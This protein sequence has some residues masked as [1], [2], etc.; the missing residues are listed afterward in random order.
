MELL[1][2]STGTDRVINWFYWDRRSYRLVLLGQTELLTGSTWRRGGGRNP[3][4]ANSALIPPKCCGINCIRCSP[5]QCWFPLDRVLLRLLIWWRVHILTEVQ[6]W[7]PGWRAL[8][9]RL[10]C[11]TFTDS[12]EINDLQRTRMDSVIRALM[13]PS[14]NHVE[15]TAALLITRITA[16]RVPVEWKARTRL[17]QVD[18]FT[19]SSHGELSKQHGCF[20]H[21]IPSAQVFD[22][23]FYS[24]ATIC[25][26]DGP[27]EVLGTSF[28]TRSEL[29]CPIISTLSIVLSRLWY[30]LNP[31]SFWSDNLSAP[32][33][34]G[35]MLLGAI[36]TW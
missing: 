6:F 25:V 32:V 10:R 4:E 24:S 22:L 11:P 12:G 34:R 3:G 16:G 18:V 1:T 9:G 30:T 2:G 31:F 15:S 19:L 13:S 14:E 36:C 8:G 23:M 7:S 17:G 26:S 21:N 29:Y 5:H 20:C 27:A 33:I 35:A 28:S